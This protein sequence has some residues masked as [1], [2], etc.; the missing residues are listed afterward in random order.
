MYKIYNLDTFKNDRT[1]YLTLIDNIVNFSK[2]F[3]NNYLDYNNWFYNIH[4]EGLGN[5]RTTL[6]STD[7]NGKI[8]GVCNIKNK[9]NEK[10]ICSLLIDNQYKDTKL[11]H[12][13][14]I[15][16]FNHL[17]STKPSIKILLEDYKYYIGIIEEYN[18]KLKEIDKQTQLYYNNKK[19]KKTK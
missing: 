8:I 1:T 9:D 11:Y 10:K 5:G 12:E 16:S 15:K 14:I 3:T 2:N 17:N 19:K 4:L 7:K 13:L 18:W 6:F